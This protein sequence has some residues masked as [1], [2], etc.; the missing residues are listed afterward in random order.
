MTVNDPDTGHA[1]IAAFANFSIVPVIDLQRGIVVH[2]R[3][4][5]RQNYAPIVT[6]LSSSAEPVAVATGLLGAVAATRLYIA[7][8]DAIQDR[9]DNL[10]AIQKIGAAHPGVELWVDGGFADEAA[11]RPLME[12]RLGRPVIGSESQRDLGFLEQLGNEAIL[13]LDFRGDEPLGPPRLH[14]T[15]S[16]WPKD[17]IV[18]TL[19][20]VGLTK[21][22]DWQRI[23][24]VQTR[25]PG[26][27]VFAAG[28][29]RGWED[30]RELQRM[31]IAGA[32]VASAI[33]DGRLRST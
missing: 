24:A 30:C 21:G 6:P 22:P 18:M 25:A 17:I 16:L 32:L 5:E 29:V 20:R 4:G 27:R 23:A 26:A 15:P 33:H 31:G 12:R 9:S 11:I 8:L 13:S 28:G 1:T 14:Q 19:A 10:E 3:G 7:D 2:A